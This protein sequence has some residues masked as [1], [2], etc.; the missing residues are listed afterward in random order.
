MSFE[1]SW[2]SV[3]KEVPNCCLESRDLLLSLPIILSESTILEGEGVVVQI[4]SCLVLPSS[5]YVGFLCSS[6]SSTLP[7]S[8]PF[9]LC[10][11]FSVN[12]GFLSSQSQVLSLCHCQFSLG[13][14]HQWFRVLSWYIAICIHFFC[15]GTLPSESW[16]VSTNI[17]ISVQHVLGS[18]FE[19]GQFW[20]QRKRKHN[21]L[22]FFNCKQTFVM[23]GIWENVTLLF[24]ALKNQEMIT[25]KETIRE[26]LM[27]PLWIN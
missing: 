11:S 9:S 4:S 23:S 16:S 13:L 24:W 22:E 14:F 26:E 25:S 21:V 2:V 10:F 20:H 27:W 5:S 17:Q 8:H 12:L 18:L 15:L 3:V 6:V 19:H 1:S 7:T